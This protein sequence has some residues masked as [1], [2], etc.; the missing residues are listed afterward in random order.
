MGSYIS[1]FGP[2]LVDTLEL[3]VEFDYRVQTFKGYSPA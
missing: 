3:L 1:V 2:Q